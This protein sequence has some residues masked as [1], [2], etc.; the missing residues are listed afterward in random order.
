LVYTIEELTLGS[1]YTSVITGDAAT[2]FEVTNTK[3]P[4]VVDVSGTKTWEDNNDQDGMRPASIHYS[5]IKERHG[6]CFQDR[7]GSGRLG[8]ELYRPAEV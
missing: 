1:G 2:G 3:T 8:M 5:S 6:D 4:E 7:D